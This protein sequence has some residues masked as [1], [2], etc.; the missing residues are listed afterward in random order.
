MHRDDFKNVATPAYIFDTS[1]LKKR[2]QAIRKALGRAKLCYAVKANPF[3]I[4]ELQEL[5]DF[6]EVC[7]PGEYEICEK[8]HI[9]A[10]KLVLS[11]VYK[12]EADVRRALSVCGARATYTAESLSQFSLL[13]LLAEKKRLRLPVLLRLSCGNQFGMDE[14]ALCGILKERDLPVNIVGVQY[15]SGTQKR[16]DAVKREVQMLA[17]LCKSYPCLR[18]VEYGPGLRVSYF[19]GDAPED[20][21]EEFSQML[22]AFPPEC[23]IVVELGRY[24]AADC[25]EYLT[26]IVDL[27]ENGGTKYCIVDGGIH[28]LKYYGQTMA[29]KLPPVA[30]LPERDGAKT[31]W[32]VCGSLCT[33]ADVLVKNLP[34]VQAREG[35]VLVF[36]KTGAYSVT[37]G[38]SLF[39]SRPLPRIYKREGGTLTLLRDF[40]RTSQINQKE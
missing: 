29:M 28:H 34:L 39:L 24:V 12:S 32:T 27:K 6:L 8:L 15:Y 3:L 1:V 17:E 35:D 20:A 19:A 10:E 16:M 21:P 26:R 25:G 9:P 5:A 36:S 18:R 11:G 31:E 2:V 7:S 23:E 33:A 13:C 40:I 22:S 14:A 30:Q 4:G 38:I 37:E